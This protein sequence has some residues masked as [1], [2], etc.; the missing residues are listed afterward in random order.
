MRALAP[1]LALSVL[2]GGLA[3]G[4]CGGGSQHAQS[5]ATDHARLSAY[6]HAVNLRADDVPGI[7]ARSPEGFDSPN[8]QI[9]VAFDC[10]GGGVVG[11]S[12]TV[13]SP[14]FVSSALFEPPRSDVA[15]QAL[16]S[17]VQLEPSVS[18]A[19][20]DVAADRTRSVEQCLG[21][22]TNA[23]TGDRGPLVDNR[24]TIT[25][26]GLALPAGGFAFSATTREHY[27]SAEPRPQQP[28]TLRARVEHALAR[29]RGLAI[30]YLGFAAG[31]SV[32][33]LVVEHEP[34]KRGAGE[35]RRLLRLL[36]DRARRHPL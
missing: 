9:S 34:G 17:S 6:A 25:S 3:L 22:Y 28:N 21:R 5:A 33:T 36:Y 27:K 35:E 31:H 26:L 29:S 8:K 16:H 7:T 23:A 12:E 18:A 14:W 13:H 11:T 4:G 2:L 1:R 30:D 24:A 32:I 20:G 19:T 15:F 10:A